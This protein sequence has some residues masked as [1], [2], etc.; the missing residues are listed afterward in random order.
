MQQNSVEIQKAED[1]MR[2]RQALPA[3]ASRTAPAEALAVILVMQR[4]SLERSPSPCRT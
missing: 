2:E 1:Y 3:G 4:S